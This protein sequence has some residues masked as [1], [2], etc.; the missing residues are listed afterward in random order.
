MPVDIRKLTWRQQAEIGWKFLRL[1]V[2]RALQGNRTTPA[3]GTPMALPRQMWHKLLTTQQSHG[4][5][6]SPP[7]SGAATLLARPAMSERVNRV[8][9]GWRWGLSTSAALPKPDASFKTWLVQRCA[10]AGPRRRYSL[11]SRAK[12]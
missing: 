7:L 9:A 11:S 1:A 3:L 8:A 12:G 4:T 2:S 10:R 5:M 6:T